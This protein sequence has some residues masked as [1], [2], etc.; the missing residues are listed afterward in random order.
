MITSLADRAETAVTWMGGTTGVVLALAA[1]AL[2]VLVVAA[3]ISALADRNTSGGGKLL[4]II[5]VLWFPLFG[6]VAWFVVGRKGHLNRFLGID[7]GR[8]R[9][10]VPVSVGQHSDAAARNGG[11]LRHA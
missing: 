2:A 6:A 11:S 7:K 1:V 9:H 5:F 4:W 3:I 10:S 8:A